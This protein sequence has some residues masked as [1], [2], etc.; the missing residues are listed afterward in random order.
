MWEQPMASAARRVDVPPGAASSA[1][2][3]GLVTFGQ[4]HVGVLVQEL[5][6]PPGQQLRGV[7]IHAGRDGR[8]RRVLGG[9]RA[10]LRRS[11]R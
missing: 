4:G 2:R 5:A 1:S 10:G 3:I 7:R 6:A 9:H 11:S 8:D